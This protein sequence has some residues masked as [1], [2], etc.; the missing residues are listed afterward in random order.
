MRRKHV[1]QSSSLP[2]GEGERWGER[3]RRGRDVVRANV[4]SAEAG[5]ATGREGKGAHTNEGHCGHTTMHHR[6]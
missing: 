3:R 1:A 6:C 2:R 5:R 4:Y